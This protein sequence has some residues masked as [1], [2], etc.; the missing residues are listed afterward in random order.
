M[1]LQWTNFLS[2]SDINKITTCL[3]VLIICLLKKTGDYKW[4]GKCPFATVDQF[5]CK[6]PQLIPSYLLRTINLYKYKWKLNNMVRKFV[7]K[8]SLSSLKFIL[9]ALFYNKI[10]LKYVS[11]SSEASEFVIV[12][13]LLFLQGFGN[14]CPSCFQNIFFACLLLVLRGLYFDD[15]PGWTGTRNFRIITS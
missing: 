3:V 10:M 13:K 4:L 1:T 7:L 5:R 14:C 12:L 8:I 11:K 15:R 2:L 9:L 6:A